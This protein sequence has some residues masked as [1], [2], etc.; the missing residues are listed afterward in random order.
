MKR[1]LTYI[2]KNGKDNY[3]KIVKVIRSLVLP[4]KSYEHF[5]VMMNV[6]RPLI[7]SLFTVHNHNN[8]IN[9]ILAS[10]SHSNQKAYYIHMY[11]HNHMTS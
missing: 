11:I 10:S 7:N 5:E 9:Y 3:I 4:N 1:N 8:P 2:N 6:Y